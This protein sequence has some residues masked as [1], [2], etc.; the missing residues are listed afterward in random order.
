VA[1]DAVLG[2]AEL[3]V[4]GALAAAVD[5]R[6]ERAVA[7]P[8]AEA[9]PADAVG[10]ALHDAVRAFSRVAPAPRRLQP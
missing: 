3:V 10:R 8:P 2:Q 4:D 1:A 6:A 7:A 9:S 5:L